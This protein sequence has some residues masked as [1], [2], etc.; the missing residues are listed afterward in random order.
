MLTLFV[1]RLMASPVFCNLFA[2]PLIGILGAMKRNGGG[3]E[4][5]P[6]VSIIVPIYNLS[7]YLQRGLDSLLQQTYTNLEIILI[8]DAS[9]D[10]SAQ[11]IAAAAAE[12]DRIVPIYQPENRGVSA[13][14]NAG[15]A[16]ASGTYIAFM[17]GDDWVEPGFI[18][19]LVRALI[20][21]KHDLV[22]SPFYTDNPESKPLPKIS[23]RDKQYSRK[24]F[25]RAM[26]M[27]VGRVRG[28]LW[29][30]IY[31]RDIIEAQHIRFDEDVAIMED[32]LFTVQYALATKSFHYLGAANYHHVVRYDSATQ[33]LGVIDALPQQVSALLRIQKLIAALPD[34]DGEVVR[35]EPETQER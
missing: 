20:A 27:P 15:L 5:Q 31:R 17:D 7:Q 29:N 16:V 9:H 14:R 3:R 33:S 19:T 21:G 35:P 26:L 23:L 6:L 22:V 4:M 34:D 11:M 24:A 8:D 1:A 10:D 13:A 12:D 18:E 28:Y 32:E 30:K 2:S 25:I